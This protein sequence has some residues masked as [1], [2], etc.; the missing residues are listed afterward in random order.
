MSDAAY[1]LALLNAIAGLATR[2]SVDGVAI[3][4]LRYDYPAFGSWELVAGRRKA[5]VRITWDGQDGHLRA[6]AGSVDAAGAI[7]AAR[8]VADRDYSR[9][10]TE[11]A[12]ILNFAYA[13]IRQHTAAA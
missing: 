8:P 12:E 7:A 2:L 1:S 4:R 13:T 10:R 6:E 3:Y 9:R 11:H 5:R